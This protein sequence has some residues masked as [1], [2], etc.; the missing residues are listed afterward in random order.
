MV[1]NKNRIIEFA[2]NNN[3]E[4]DHVNGMIYGNYR[5]YDLSITRLQKQGNFLVFMILTGPNG[6]ATNETFSDLQSSVSKVNSANARNNGAVNFETTASIKEATNFDNLQAAL[7]T[8]TNYLYTKGLKS[9]CFGC[10]KDV[11]TSHYVFNG[12]GLQMCEDC[13]VKFS[14]RVAGA[15]E[16]H[17]AKPENVPFGIVGA[18]LGSLAGVLAIVIIGQLGYVAAISGLI[19]AVCTVRGY[20]KFAGKMSY[21]GIFISIAVMIAMTF[22]GNR[23]DWAVFI[24]RELEVGI[25]EAY[26]LV[27]KLADES[28]YTSNLIMTGFF[29][30]IG[31]LTTIISVFKGAGKTLALVKL[32]NKF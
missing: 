14:E 8:L 31:S 32:G 2:K 13:A 30:L 23:M 5:G 11:T 20:E 29:A 12:M 4:F 26:S 21:T 9:G 16:E 28:M 6:N 10:D 15:N 3:L 19:L 18:L 22:F 25:F 24:M 1:A 17:K 27:P 7:D